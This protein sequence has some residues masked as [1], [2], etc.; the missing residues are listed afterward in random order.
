MSRTDKRE[1]LTFVK[2]DQVLPMLGV[3]RTS[4]NGASVAPRYSSVPMI[5]TNF[6]NIGETEME[7][8]NS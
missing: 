8:C 6:Y 7:T 1:T 3:K 4:T 5:S 2:T